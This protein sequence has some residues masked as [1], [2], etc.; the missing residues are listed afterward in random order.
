MITVNKFFRA[1][2]VYHWSQY[3]FLTLFQKNKQ[4][5]RSEIWTR[6]RKSRYMWIKIKYWN[7]TTETV[8]F[9]VRK[10]HRQYEGQYKILNQIPKHGRLS[11]YHNSTKWCGK[12]TLKY[13]YHRSPY[14]L[15]VNTQRVLYNIAQGG[16]ANANYYK[17]MENN[18]KAIEIYGSEIGNNPKLLIC[19]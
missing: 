16:L 5:L 14:K 6:L 2:K 9:V 11:E 10:I 13:N 7:T 17:K 1:W 8:F 15:Y 18:V 3:H 19:I 4:Q 12:I